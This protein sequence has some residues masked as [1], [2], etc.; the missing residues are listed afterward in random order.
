MKFKKTGTTKSQASETP[1]MNESFQSS[2]K[3]PVVK[4][5]SPKEP[6]KFIGRFSKPQSEPEQLSVSVA[7]VIKTERIASPVKTI[8]TPATKEEDDP[9]TV[10]LR[11]EERK[12]EIIENIGDL[13]V[14]QNG[15]MGKK[16]N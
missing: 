15:L 5:E 1:Q 3:T 16:S 10:R 7:K 4:N 9:T 8:N 12:S 11:L 14:R 13:I 2:E 6:T